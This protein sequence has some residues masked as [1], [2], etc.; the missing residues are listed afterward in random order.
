MRRC[1]RYP[2]GDGD[3]SATARK[4]G[5]TDRMEVDVDGMFWGGFAVGMSAT[6][7]LLCCAAIALAMAQLREQRNAAR[8]QRQEQESARR[9]INDAV[10][11]GMH[12][13]LQKVAQNATRREG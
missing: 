3:I 7:A 11:R 1:S 9:A 13:G 2:Q 5:Q 12:E 6:L 10:A 8:E 4:Q